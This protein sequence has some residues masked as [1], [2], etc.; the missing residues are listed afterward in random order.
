MRVCVGVVL[1]CVPE[2]QTSFPSSPVCDSRPLAPAF[3]L[4][5]SL[6]VSAS[7]SL[8]QSRLCPGGRSRRLQLQ[9]RSRRCCGSSSRRRHRRRYCYCCCSI[10]GL[11]CKDATDLMERFNLSGLQRSLMR[12]AGQCFQRNAWGLCLMTATGCKSFCIY[13][14]FS[15]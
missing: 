1:C 4:S 6:S 9:R 15:E 14:D 2:C 3:S 12:Q 5:L 8:T 10:G 13:S 7:G 11:Q